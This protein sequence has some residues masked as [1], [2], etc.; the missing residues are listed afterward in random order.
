MGAKKGKTQKKAA[1]K[2]EEAVEQKKT[3]EAPEENLQTQPEV[4]PE[5]EPKEVLKDHE[6][7]HS[8]V[9]DGIPKVR[10]K[11]YPSGAVAYIKHN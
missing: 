11:I 8:V 10:K 1:P 5:P 7:K 4:K 3:E 6:V 9:V 2:N